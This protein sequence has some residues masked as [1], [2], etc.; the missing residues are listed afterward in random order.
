VTEP[1]TDS[2]SFPEPDAAVS[3]E[4]PTR[5]FCKRCGASWQPE[6]P[7]CPHCDRAGSLGPVAAEI[8]ADKVAIRRAVILYAMLLGVSIISISVSLVQNAP[9]GAG[10]LAVES[11]LFAIITACFI[12][13]A[14][15]QALAAYAH[16]GSAIWYLLAPLIA[17]GTVAI[18]AGIIHALHVY[19][20]VEELHYLDVFK[21]YRNPLLVGIFWIALMPALTEETAF[22]GLILGFLRPVL[23]DNEV[24]LVSAGMFA[25]L[26]LS[27]VGFPHL[28]LLGS[29]LAFVRIKS[30]SIYPGM[31]IHFSHNLFVLILEHSGH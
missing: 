21:H 8:S 29:V 30:R 2:S 14:P 15:R 16:T 17:L 31:L 13:L 27:P 19:A 10:G 11:A 25:I 12:F 20:G 26:H 7:T 1:T 22:R 9:L 24:I 6:W 23:S 3:L 28:F 18:A 4:T 5:R